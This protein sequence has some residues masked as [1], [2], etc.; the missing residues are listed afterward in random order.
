MT[1]AVKP[2]EGGKK[3]SYLVSLMG[4]E[5]VISSNEGS[6]DDSEDD[7]ANGEA[8]DMDDGPRYVEEDDPVKGLNV[9]PSKKEEKRLRRPWKKTLIIKLLGKKIG[10]GFLKKKIDAIWANAGTVQLIDLGNE[11][12]L[13]RLSTLE[14]F[15]FALTGGP[16]MIFDH[17]LTVRQWQED[18]NLHL[19]GISKIAAWVRFPDLP[20]E[21]YD[22]EFLTIMGNKI[23][24]TLKVDLTTTMQTRGKFARVCVQVDLEKPLRAHYRLKGRP[25]R[26]EYEG[27]HLIC[28]LCGK[29]GHEKD[30]CIHLIRPPMASP[31][32]QSSLP[33]EGGSNKDG[34]G[35]GGSEPIPQGN[36]EGNFGP[37]M[38]V[39]RSRRPRRVL[40]KTANNQEVEKNL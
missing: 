15:E 30:A 17:Y 2:A 37:W 28:F 16:W 8:V 35:S 31:Q 4:E 1:D 26:I 18:F 9:I 38:L 39:T 40:P 6:S 34:K 22:Q 36:A 7:R 21:F 14:D 11:F 32:D 10:F 19:E 23:G 12:F 25:M 3:K 20:I 33:Q 24:K 5:I 27:I 13:A 29:Y